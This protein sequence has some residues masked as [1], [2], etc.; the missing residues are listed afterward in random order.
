LNTDYYASSG[1]K[2]DAQCN[3]LFDMLPRDCLAGCGASR[4]LSSALL[5]AHFSAAREMP[6]ATLPCCA[7]LQIWAV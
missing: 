6:A 3:A 1:L 4:R 5:P 7:V 2:D